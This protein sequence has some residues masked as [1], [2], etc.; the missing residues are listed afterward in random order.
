MNN[1]RIDLSRES[2]NNEG[3][4]WLNRKTKQLRTSLGKNEPNSWYNPISSYEVGSENKLRRGQP[5]S[6]GYLDQLYSESKLSGDSCIVPTNPSINQWCIGLALEPGFHRDGNSV[7][8]IHVQS[9]GQIEYDLSTKDDDDYYLPPHS[10]TKFEWN[11]DD[12]GKPVFVSNKNPGELTLDIAEAAYNGGTIVCVGRIADAPL[13]DEKNI[14]LQKIILEVQLSGDVRGVVDTSQI[15]VEIANKSKHA[16]LGIQIENIESDLDRVFFFFIKDGFAYFILDDETVNKYS[17]NSPVGALV[18]NSKDSVLDIES[19]L[20]KKTLVFRL[21]LLK[22]NFGFSK[23]GNTAYLSNGSIDE[24]AASSSY[25]YKVGLILSKDSILIDC[26]YPRFVAKKTMIGDIK[27]LFENGLCEPGYAKVDNEV[28]KVIFDKNDP[29]CAD[30]IDW[31]YLVEGTYTK[32]LFVFSRSKDGPFTTILEG[33][34]TPDGANE[35]STGFLNKYTYFKFRDLVYTI[36]NNTCGC[37]IKFSK[38]DAPEAMNYIWPEQTFELSL[39]PDP[40]RGDD[41]NYVLGG[42]LSSSKLKLDISKLTALGQYMDSNGQNIEAYDII[43][44]EK[45][46]NQLI[47]SGFYQ[48]ESNGQMKWCGYEWKVSRDSYTN[49]TFLTMITVPGEE[50]NSK[51]LGFCWPIGQKLTSK[52]DLYVTVRRRPTQY[53]DLYLNQINQNNP[54]APYTDG[55]NLITGDSIFFGAKLKETPADSGVGQNSGYNKENIGTGEIHFSSSNNEGSINTIITEPDSNENR[56]NVFYDIKS[57]ATRAN[58]DEI[59]RYIKWGYNFE[60]NITTLSSAFAPSLVQ[61]STRNKFIFGFENGVHTDAVDFD[62]K[63]A[64]IALHE[65][66]PRILS[67]ED[68]DESTRNNWKKI[69]YIFDEVLRAKDT[70][71]EYTLFNSSNKNVKYKIKDLDKV[72]NVVQY[73]YG[74]S[75]GYLSYISNIGLLNAAAKDIQNRL[76][77]IE[78]S[79]FGL[80]FETNPAGKSNA[81]DY[82]IID[83]TVSNPGLLRDVSSLRRLGLIQDLDSNKFAQ[84]SSFGI[85][86]VLKEFFASN[87]LEYTTEDEYKESIADFNVKDVFDPDLSDSKHQNHL[88]TLWLD[89]CYNRKTNVQLSKLN[90]FITGKR[91]YY[92]YDHVD[93]EEDGIHK[94][95]DQIYYAVNDFKQISNSIS[96]DK[97]YLSKYQVPY[98]NETKKVSPKLDSFKEYAPWK[99]SFLKWPIYSDKD[100]EIVDLY[101]NFFNN[102]YAGINDFDGEKETFS[103]QSL[104]GLIVDIYTKL[105]YIR[106]KI[107]YD[108]NFKISMW[109]KLEKFIGSDKFKLESEEMTFEDGIYSAFSVKNNLI[110]S[111]YRTDLCNKHTI[112]Y[113][114]NYIYDEHSDTGFED[115]FSAISRWDYTARSVRV[116]LYGYVNVLSK[117]V[118][119][120]NFIKLCSYAFELKTTTDVEINKFIASNPTLCNDIKNCYHLLSGDYSLSTF[121]AIKMLSQLKFSIYKTMIIENQTVG[122]YEDV[123]VFDKAFQDIQG[124]DQKDLINRWISSLDNVFNKSSNL[125]HRY[126]IYD[127]PLEADLSTSIKVCKILCPDFKD[128]S[129]ELRARFG[130]NQLRYEQSTFIYSTLIKNMI[131]LY[132]NKVDEHGILVN[133]QNIS[134]PDQIPLNDISNNINDYLYLYVHSREAPNNNRIKYDKIMH[135]THLDKVN[136]N[137]DDIIFEKRSKVISKFEDINKILNTPEGEPLVIDD[138]KYSAGLSTNEKIEHDYFD[139]EFIKF[140]ENELPRNGKIYLKLSSLKEQFSSYSDSLKEFLTTDFNELLESISSNFNE[141]VETAASAIDELELQTPFIILPKQQ[142]VQGEDSSLNVEIEVKKDENSLSPLQTEAKTV[143]ISSGGCSISSKGA[144]K[145]QLSTTAS[146][147]TSTKFDVVNGENVVGTVDLNGLSIPVSVELTTDQIRSI[148]NVVTPQSNIEIPSSNVIGNLKA[149]IDTS[150]LDLFIDEAKHEFS[151]KEDEDGSAIK[152]QNIN[153][154]IKETVREVLSRLSLEL[155]SDFEAMKDFTSND[156]VNDLKLESEMILSQSAEQEA[157]EEPDISLGHENDLLIER[158]GKEYGFKYSYETDYSFIEKIFNNKSLN[159]KVDTVKATENLNTTM[160]TFSVEDSEVYNSINRLQP[161]L[162]NSSWTYSSNNLST[163]NQCIEFF[164]QKTVNQ[165]VFSAQNKDILKQVLTH[166]FKEET[167]I[168]FTEIDFILEKCSEKLRYSGSSDI[169]DF[170]YSIHQLYRIFENEYNKNLNSMKSNTNMILSSKI[171]DNFRLK[172]KQQKRPDIMFSISGKEVLDTFERRFT[173]GKEVKETSDS[174]TLQNWSGISDLVLSDI[175]GRA[176]HFSFNGRQYFCD[177]FIVIKVDDCSV[178]QTLAGGVMITSQG[179]A[180]FNKQ[181]FIGDKNF[182]L[183]PM[184]TGLGNYENCELVDIFNKGSLSLMTLY[185]SYEEKEIFEE[186]EAVNDLGDGYFVSYVPKEGVMEIGKADPKVD[187]TPIKIDFDEKLDFLCKNSV[188]LKVSDFSKNFVYEKKLDNSLEVASI[189]NGF[190][191]VSLDQTQDISIQYNKS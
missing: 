86:S 117:A 187:R 123:P 88:Y 23:V 120:I 138:N 102:P 167:D 3:N 163:Y 129:P 145:V 104:E 61:P 64:L 25:D 15:Q 22:G 50:P 105:S 109:S 153:D 181:V 143:Q 54:W 75:N 106:K 149:D 111:L 20:G 10:D 67:Y 8:K 5:V 83:E 157:E 114:N 118:Q 126:G 166:F 39:V 1:D 53:H 91:E 116:E 148:I 2:L 99:G 80:D 35:D 84:Q 49:Q 56:I 43:V 26:R 160:T 96:A 186:G 172:G 151:P 42:N 90:S 168:L 16:S 13:K 188:L 59:R 110:K 122:Y 11:Y 125:V 170:D 21:G 36:G 28:H 89:Y 177:K 51:C 154:I 48:V 9:N 107:D 121:Q 171:K 76:L 173:L 27:P 169:N 182:I 119:L 133:Y 78:R 191:P 137:L 93:I 65:F 68:E 176:I 98:L 97:I 130:G 74:A 94:K 18:V 127:K 112:H 55:N 45:T 158:K 161:E 144:G 100:F 38:D 115:Y 58:N 47:S 178:G 77:K 95:E 41:E 179:K 34:W 72:S 146:I 147:S 70:E 62:E 79:L 19:L 71:N 24:S 30:G 29:I 113:G 12:I 6:V 81:D 37:Q 184:I 155:P 40:G 164:E 66:Q 85:S 73:L 33:G 150:T 128:A 159:K 132:S 17:Q 131:D 124:R 32:D 174:S 141:S 190:A 103:A 57:V 4:I 44:R 180:S 183:L 185:T 136:E 63:N 156:Y 142:V 108:E 134:D 69:S 162:N 60:D 139:E 52:V 14:S 82:E 189:I 165:I 175:Y 87:Y 31:K 101:D 92:T 140:G 135:S 152:T 7:K 46:S